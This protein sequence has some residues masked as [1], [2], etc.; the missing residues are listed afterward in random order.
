MMNGL[1]QLESITLDNK[2]RS[3]YYNIIY[4]AKLRTEYFEGE[5]HHIFPRFF[6]G[7]DNDSNLVKLTFKEHYICHLLLIKFTTGRQYYKSVTAFWFMSHISRYNINVKSS[8]L[9]ENLKTQYKQDTSRRMKS[10]W[11]DEDFRSRQRRARVDSWTEKRRRQQSERLLELGSP[12]KNPDIHRKTIER[13][14]QNGTNI[15]VTNNPMHRESTKQKKLLS[16]PSKRGMKP[17]INQR[18]GE[19]KM[20]YKSPGQEWIQKCWA[21]GGSS[22]KGKPKKKV[23]CPYCNKQMAPHTLNRHIKAKHHENQ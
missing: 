20:S 12:F 2:Y 22:L 10:M 15:F 18:T 17:W 14:T 21:P 5:W 3:W 8:R 4:R 6:G 13:R 7:D 11:K 23:D 1:H 16:T 19:R 9:Y